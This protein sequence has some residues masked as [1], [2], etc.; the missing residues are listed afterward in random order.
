MGVIAAQAVLIHDREEE[1]D[2]PPALVEREEEENEQDRP[3][4]VCEVVDWNGSWYAGRGI[5]LRW[6]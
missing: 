4:H 5:G 3:V 6:G 2:L 1:V